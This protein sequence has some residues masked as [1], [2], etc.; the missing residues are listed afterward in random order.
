MAYKFEVGDRVKVVKAMDEIVE[1]FVGIR[2]TVTHR[3]DDPQLCYSVLLDGH[4][5]ELD[6]STL[7][8][9]QELEA[10]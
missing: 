5:E 2:G 9:T 1:Q 7:F 3:R 10:E 8:Y 6:G 4:D